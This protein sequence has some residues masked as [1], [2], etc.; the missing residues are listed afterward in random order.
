MAKAPL[1]PA[2]PLPKR[3]Y[4]TDDANGYRRN[5]RYILASIAIVILAPFIWLQ[6]TKDKQFARQREKQSKATDKQSL[7]K[8]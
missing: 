8:N 7:P 3:K 5:F 6:R 2:A 4:R 1:Y